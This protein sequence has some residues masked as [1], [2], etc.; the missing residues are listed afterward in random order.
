MNDHRARQDLENILNEIC[1]TW[2]SYGH[3]GDNLWELAEKEPICNRLRSYEHD[4]L[5]P[6]LISLHVSNPTNEQ[7]I[8]QFQ[9]KLVGF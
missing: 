6:K 4:H 1:E 2:K 9:V 3:P 5:D 7:K 8:A